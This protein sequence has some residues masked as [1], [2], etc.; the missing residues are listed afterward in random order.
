MPA[1]SHELNH[2]MSLLRKLRPEEQRMVYFELRRHH[3]TQ[4][5][6]SE[7]A[8]NADDWLLSGLEYELRKRGLLLTTLSE[9]RLNAWAPNFADQSRQL[10][11]QLK[12]RLTR[13]PTHAFLLG[14][15]RS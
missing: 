13:P 7:S 12:A 6:A 8:A 2:V 15:G 4:S 3:G 5:P 14:L 1:A 10:R 9:A 11:A